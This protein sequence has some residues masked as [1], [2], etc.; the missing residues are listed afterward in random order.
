M[1][2]GRPAAARR[3]D[4]H[5]PTET[6]YAERGLCAAIDVLT[7]APAIT[8]TPVFRLTP[9]FVADASHVHGS[10]SSDELR[11]WAGIRSAVDP[12]PVHDVTQFMLAQVAIREGTASS[13]RRCCA[14]CAVSAA[15]ASAA[16]RSPISTS[17]ATADRRAG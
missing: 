6:A 14:R 16:R 10:Q 9:F 5:D 4:P 15:S 2:V 7:Y 17:P 8:P 1:L 12:G 3:A 13:R 11:R